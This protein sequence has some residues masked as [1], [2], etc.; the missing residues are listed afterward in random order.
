VKQNPIFSKRNSD[1]V[2]I[3]LISVTMRTRNRA[4]YLKVAVES[5]RG[6]TFSDWEL[7]I[8]DDASTDETSV[9]GQSFEQSDPRVHYIRHEPALGASSNWRFC[10]ASSRGKYFAALDDDNRYLPHFLEKAVAALEASP[11]I[12]FV[13][14]DEWRID[15]AGKRDEGATETASAHY[16]RANLAAGL[17]KDMALLAVQQAPSINAS[18]F[19]REALV[20]AGGFRELAGDF[21]DFD[22]FLNLA[23]QSYRAAYVAERLVEYRQHGDQDGA[24]YLKSVEKAR[25]FLSILESVSFGG[26]AEQARSRKL[27][28]AHLTLSR[29]LLLNNDIAA[30]REAVRAALRLQ[31]LTLRPLLLAAILQ[32]PNSLIQHGLER[33]YGNQTAGMKK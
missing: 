23:A 22:V 27:A 16:Q 28:Q 2:S 8:S 30:A 1:L 26:Q 5:V 4:N 7:I 12:S 14:S 9:V 11:G 13:F 31:P 24:T 29:T 15:A 19:D 32:L 10:L 21:A 3:P 17:C 20:Q 18:V 25:S 33:R 6:Q